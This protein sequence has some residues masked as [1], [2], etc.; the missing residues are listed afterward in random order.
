MRNSRSIKSIISIMLFFFMLAP[1]SSYAGINDELIESAK[2]GDINKIKSLLEKGDKGA[3]INAKGG[4]FDWTALMYAAGRGQTEAIELLIAHGADVNAKNKAGWTALMSAAL[5]GQTEAV[6]LL[7]DRG[8]DIEAKD[9]GGLTAL[10]FAAMNGQTEAVRLLI[11]RGADI[12]AK[13]NKG[14]TALIWAAEY[15]HTSA[16]ELLLNKGAHIGTALMWAAYKGKTEAIKLLIEKGA[17]VNAKDNEGKT[18]LMFAARGGHTEA[19]RLLIAKGADVHAKDKYSMTALMFAAGNGRAEAIKLLIEKGADVNAKDNEG[20][21]ALMFAAAKVHT[22]AIKV[23]I[24]KGA[25][26]HVGEEA[27]RHFD[28]GMAA[29][30]MAKNP[31]DYEKA[32]QE[33]EMA[34]HLAPHWADVY[35]NLGL[36]QEKVG[37]YGDAVTN[38]K[39]YLLLAPNA[40]D[41]VAVK[42]H[43][44]KIE[45]KKERAQRE[46]MDPKNLVGVWEPVEGPE[47]YRFEIRNNKGKIEGGLRREK[48]VEELNLIRGPWFVP[49][50]WDGRSL[51]I[52]NTKFFYCDFSVQRD[53]C[54]EDASL[55]LIMVDR[56]TFK[57]TMRVKPHP[58]EQRRGIVDYY[59]TEYTWKRSK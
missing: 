44:N 52:P 49:I 31:E 11:D 58:I 33:L 50:Q 24:E 34:V 13:D 36:I 25:V 53:C 48:I 14:K 3:D 23:L 7:I 32:I 27:K 22:E 9:M 57:G 26:V 6:R 35:Y 4:K 15:S 17:D 18:A 12:E 21:T 8:A 5:N 45:Y 28:R 47:L 10:I 2:T 59:I 38:L 56:D 43:I 41:A 30:E 40:S 54:P 51:V 19:V 55:S 46:L 1:F 29:V 16:I 20:K 37:K 39:Q 42:S